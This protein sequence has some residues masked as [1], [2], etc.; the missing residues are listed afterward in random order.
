MANSV[1]LSSTFFFLSIWRGSKK[2]VKKVKSAIMNYVAG[3]KLQRA[4]IRVSWHQC[5]QTKSKGGVNLINLEDAATALLT[6]WLIKAMEPGDSNLHLF[7][8]FRLSQY[9]PYSGGRWSQSLEYFTLSKHQRKKGSLV[10]NQVAAAWRNMLPFVSTNTPSNWE[11]LMN[12]SFWWPLACPTLDAGFSMVRAAYLHKR[13][14][15]YYRDIWRGGRFLT[16]PEA[17]EKFGLLPPEFSAWSTVVTHLDRM[18]GNLIRFSPRKLTCGEWMAI[19]DDVGDLVPTVVCRAKEGFQPVVG[20]Y[21]VKIPHK[22]QLFKIKW[23]SRT[24]EEIPSDSLNLPSAWGEFG[25]DTVQLCC[26]TV[27]R[28]RVLEAIK[29]PKK[30]SIWW[31][32]GPISKLVWDPGRRQWP[33]AKNLMK[34]TSNQGRELLR[35][36]TN[37][38][39]V[40]VKKWVGILP[41]DYKLRWNN[42]WDT[43]RVRKEA[44]LIWMV[45][46][47]AVAVN[48]WRGAI[49]Q[50]IDQSYPVCLRG[51]RETVMHSFWECED[52]RR[53]WLWGEAIINVMGPTGESRAEQP[54]DPVGRPNMYDTR[55]TVIPNGPV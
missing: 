39:N 33:E 5:C 38:P 1:L 10:W 43:E 7:L 3:G 20:T 53:A 19:F 47:K 9:Q 26:G 54:A 12:C 25:E 15:K 48:A 34:Y 41:S 32:Y 21:T 17:Q 52:S 4:R 6:K 46:H 14:L 24:L 27:C 29:G 16:P 40:I 36:R 23:M 28:V 44:G 42:I 11:K 51:I 49:S 35:Q 2:G 30:T 45:W 22:V 50:E 13:G 37:T 8:R 18:W 55:L 31:Y